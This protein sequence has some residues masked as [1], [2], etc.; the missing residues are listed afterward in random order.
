MGSILDETTVA[1]SLS[2]PFSEKL[3]EDLVVALDSET[4]LSVCLAKLTLY[5]KICLEKL[6]E[7]KKVQWMRGRYVAKQ[8][9]AQ[10]LLK[11]TDRQY[12]L[13]QIEIHSTI[14]GIPYGVNIR[15]NE[16]ISAHL[17]ISHTH[18]CVGAHASNA[19][20]TQGV[21]I[22]IE[23]VRIF[24]AE[25]VASFLS[26]D[27]YA[28]YVT[29]PEIEKSTYVT[30]KWCIKEAYLK[31]KGYGLMIHPR[32][33]TCMNGNDPHDIQIFLYGQPTS[34]TSVYWTSVSD[35]YI[36]VSITL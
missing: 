23:C 14:S 13:D 1:M 21:G 18:G 34:L 4:P 19:S 24:K 10:Y 33:V 35:L 27:E 6:S 20:L 8:A 26:A 15:S 36:L 31:A 30:L 7:K 17:S 22:D 16:R 3:I 12:P 5:E 29:L 11:K 32:H 2:D 28:E 9:L 25:T